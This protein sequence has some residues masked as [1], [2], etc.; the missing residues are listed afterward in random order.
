MVPAGNKANS[1]SSVN[2]TTKTIHHVNTG[3]AWLL[4]WI[5]LKTTREYPK[6]HTTKMRKALEIK[7]S[8]FNENIKDLN[9]DEGNL[10]KTK[11]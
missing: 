6:N 3:W 7:K 8:K 11:T 1:L 2:H 5:L 4:N 10:V 9:R